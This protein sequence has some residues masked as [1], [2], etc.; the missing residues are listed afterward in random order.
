MRGF[1]C[2]RYRHRLHHLPDC[3]GLAQADELRYAGTLA[4]FYLFIQ[5]YWYGEIQK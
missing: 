2:I 1:Y 5:V 4:Y 3:L